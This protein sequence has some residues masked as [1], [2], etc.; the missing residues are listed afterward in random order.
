MGRLS[1]CLSV[2]LSV[3]KKDI[4]I[5]LCNWIWAGWS[6]NLNVISF[7]LSLSFRQALLLTGVDVRR[8]Q[9]ELFAKDEMPTLLAPHTWLGPPALRAQASNQIL[10]PTPGRHQTAPRSAYRMVGVMVMVGVE[11]TTSPN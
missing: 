8:L 9:A 3:L 6:S 4:L 11:R 2:P 5:Y 7:R 10:F 1:Q